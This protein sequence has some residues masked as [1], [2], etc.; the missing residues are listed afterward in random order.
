MLNVAIFLV[1]LGVAMMLGGSY[2]R[3]LF[4]DGKDEPRETISGGF[5]LGGLWNR[6]SGFVVFVVGLF[7][8]VI[9][10]VWEILT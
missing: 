9:A 4:K 1:V 7:A 10:I 3:W 8:V 5:Y 6:R 2:D